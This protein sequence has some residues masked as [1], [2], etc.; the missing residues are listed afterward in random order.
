MFFGS[1]AQ[2]YNRTYTFRIFFSLAAS[3][4]GR[5]TKHFPSHGRLLYIIMSIG[6]ADKKNPSAENPPWNAMWSD[7]RIVAMGTRFAEANCAKI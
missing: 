1:R 5:H 7:L 2:G 4:Y 6:A 3:A